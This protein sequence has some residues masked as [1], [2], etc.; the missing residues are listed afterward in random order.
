M[1]SGFWKVN[2]KNV[3]VGR[4]STTINSIFDSVV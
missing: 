4:K 1:S 2:T 3:D